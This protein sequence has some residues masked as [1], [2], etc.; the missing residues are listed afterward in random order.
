MS[1]EQN[2]AAME[3]KIKELGPERVSRHC[4]DYTKVNVMDVAISSV[5]NRTSFENALKA[6]GIK[7]LIENDCYH[8]EIKQK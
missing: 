5:N 6:N 3:S 7:Y 8:L 1:R 4:G 2:I